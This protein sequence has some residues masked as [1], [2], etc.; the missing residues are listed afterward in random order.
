VTADRVPRPG[1]VA[2]AIAGILLLQITLAWG[3]MSLPFLD[4]RQHYNYDNALF[5]VFAR[6]GILIGDA[7]SQMGITEA[8]YD[9]WDKPTGTPRYYTHHPFL[10]KAAFQLRVRRFGESEASSRTFALAVSMAAAAGAVAALAIASGSALAA[11]LGTAVMVATPLFATFELCIKYEIDGMAVGTWLL[12]TAFL[13]LKRPGRGT[14]AALAVLAVLAPLAHWTALILVAFLVV[15]LAAERLVLGERDA[16]PP[17][18]ALI[19]GAGLGGIVLLASVVWLKG[20]WAPFWSD[21][22]A[23][24]HA[25]QDVSML[26]AGEWGDR[27]RTFAVFN[28]TLLLLWL[29]G[30]LAAINAV[31]WAIQRAPGARPSG[32]VAERALPA[33]CLCTLATASIWV[34][35]FPQA[36]FIHYY[37]QLW[38]VLPLA[39]LVTSSIRLVGPGALPGLVSRAATVI[40]V[41]WLVWTTTGWTRRLLDDQRGTTDDIAFLR[42]FRTDRFDRFVFIPTTRDS[43]NLWFSGPIFE[44]YTAR[45]IV[46][47]DPGVILTPGDKVLLLRSEGRAG[48]LAKIDSLLG[49]HLADER[50]GARIC[51]YDVRRR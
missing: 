50:C 19:A 40:L 42:S 26:Q 37:M 27:Q 39:A 10:F 48:M 41:A 17:L 23:V 43:F 1:A 18:I 8:H 32:T 21:Q 24:F 36:S 2:W 20:G 31:G 15:W 4:G 14:L 29:A 5:S 35:G 47:Y 44:Y 46:R 12:A 38:Y 34:F 33:F 13:C 9:S 22:S 45:S 30:L 16:G 7:R 49:I 11:G 51:A 6:T 3:R 28:F 25:R